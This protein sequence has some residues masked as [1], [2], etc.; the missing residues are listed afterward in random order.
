MVV[1]TE[2]LTRKAHDVRRQTFEIVVEDVND[3]PWI[4]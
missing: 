3:H 1:G 4:L 2:S